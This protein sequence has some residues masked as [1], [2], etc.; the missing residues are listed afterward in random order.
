MDRASSS[1][2]SSE[3][4]DP[5]AQATDAFKSLAGFLFGKNKQQ[6]KYSMTMPVI[7]DT[8]G[9]MRFILP[10]SIKVKAIPCL[11]PLKTLRQQP[12]DSGNGTKPVLHLLGICS[13]SSWLRYMLLCPLGVSIARPGNR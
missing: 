6:K 11:L 1:N 2:G 5:A 4:K 13:C 10:S 7:T 3:Q 8:T 9:K 12:D